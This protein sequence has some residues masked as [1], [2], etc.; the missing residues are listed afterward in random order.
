M[1]HLRSLYFIYLLL[2]T[3]LLFIK[4]GRKPISAWACWHNSKDVDF[5]SSQIF[6]R[7]AI[8]S[9]PSLAQEVENILF[10]KNL[11]LFLI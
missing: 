6:L 9:S 3:L 11:L 2:L 1:E 5:S 4:A 10:A 8:F 7:N